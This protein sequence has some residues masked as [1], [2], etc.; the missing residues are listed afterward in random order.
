M[1]MKDDDLL[2]GH[3]NATRPITTQ[4]QLASTTIPNST[5]IPATTIPRQ[6]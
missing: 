4:I 1:V 5:T 3:T 6:I 2:A